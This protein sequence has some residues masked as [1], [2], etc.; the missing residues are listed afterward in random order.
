M[1]DLRHTDYRIVIGLRGDLGK[2]WN[3]DGYLQYG[4]VAAPARSRPA[5]STR[6]AIQQALNVVQTARNG[7]R[8]RRP[9]PTPAACR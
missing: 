9:A 8:L 4:T 3:Y 7:P 1:T 2:N 5:T 6:P